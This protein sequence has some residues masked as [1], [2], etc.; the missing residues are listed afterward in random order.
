MSE[1]VEARKGGAKQGDVAKRGADTAWP[2]RRVTPVLTRLVAASGGAATMASF[3]PATL[4]LETCEPA[5]SAD[6]NNHERTQSLC[7]E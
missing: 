6:T 7:G 5:F 2:V 1:Q 3:D 4:A